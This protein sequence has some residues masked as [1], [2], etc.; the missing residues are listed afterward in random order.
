MKWVVLFLF[1]G[2]GLASLTAGLV[3]G[4][5][6]AALFRTGLIAQGRV[7]AMHQG[8]VVDDEESPRPSY[9]PMVEFRTPDGRSFQ[10]KGSTGS[11]SPEFTIGAEVEVR[12]NPQKPQQAQLAKFSHFW[13][14]PLLLTIG[15]LLAL[16]LASGVFYIFGDI[17]GGKSPAGRSIRAR[18]LEASGKA[19]R[20]EGRI[21]GVRERG[22]GRYV[23]I[24]RG[25][26]PGSD[27]EEDFESEEFGVKPEG[28][29]IGR[30]VIILINPDKKDEY[31]VELGPLLKEVVE[32]QSR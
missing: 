32:N 9:Y 4:A 7:V 16:F 18:M 14:G 24:C 27:R 13:L 20:I 6:R 12:Y 31:S 23:F 5:K 25:A 22:R 3:W 17:E 26:R 8:E 28:E 10:F 1:G 15:G 29:L 11:S 19:V 30:S 2:L 21:T